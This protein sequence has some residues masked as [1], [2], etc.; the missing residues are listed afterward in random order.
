MQ[1]LQSLRTEMENLMTK[2]KYLNNID[3]TT[4][5]NT[6]DADSIIIPQPPPY[7]KISRLKGIE[8]NK[9][10]LEIQPHVVPT[11]ICGNGCSVN[12]KGSRL[13]ETNF[14]IKPPFSRCVPHTSPGTIHRLCISETMSQADAKALYENL[15][16]LLKHF[17][18]SLK[19][20]EMLT[21]SPNL[22]EMHDVH[23][24]NWGSTRMAG[25][26]DACLQASDI[27]IPFLYTIIGGN[28]RPEETSYIANP[29]GN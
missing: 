10:I 16:P 2:Y 12:V 20:S 19:S 3:P 17:A 24:R 8:R 28:I 7:F 18:K 14:R 15:R 23:L 1:K 11:S 27:I 4:I 9:I 6:P 21:T 22:L 29:K 26:L 5:A 25:F 13:L